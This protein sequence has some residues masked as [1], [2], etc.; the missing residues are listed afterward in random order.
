MTKANK[1]MKIYSILQ[2]QFSAQGWW[3]IINDRTLLCE[4]HTR[5]PKNDS[6]RFEIAIGALLT[7]GTQWYP[8]VVR[9]IQQLKLGREF[10]KQ[11]LEVIRRVEIS[12]G[13]NKKL[14]G[15]SILTQNTN[16]KNV[17]KAIINLNK[18]G[19]L[20]IEKIKAINKKKLANLVKPSGYYNQ[21]AE[22][23]KLVARFFSKNKNPT[24][25]QL[26]AVKGIGPETADSI[27]LYAFNRPIF[28][29]D[30]YTKRIFS[31]IG[32]CK[33]KCEYHELQDLFH[34]A[35]PRSP[36]LFNEYHALLVELAKR[37]CTKK[38]SCSSC[39]INKFCKKLI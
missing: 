19:I 39:P 11:E 24:R 18:V 8:N 26:L 21:K 15:M 30:A 12:T 3:P 20:S 16:W 37:N 27:L 9:A 1:L 38:P 29:I 4:Y 23:L 25:E 5:A 34:K 13:N 14:T 6:E 22:R 36:K 7:Q 35:L 2:E 31:R 32:M 10:T 17:E 28:V 33:D